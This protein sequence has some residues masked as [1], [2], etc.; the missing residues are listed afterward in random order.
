MAIKKDE[1]NVIAKRLLNQRNR[2]EKI[3]ALL[4]ADMAC[5]KKLISDRNVGQV[6]LLSIQE[7][8][9]NKDIVEFLSEELDADLFNS[10]KTDYWPTDEEF[11]KALKCN[12]KILHAKYHLKIEDQSEDVKDILDIINTKDSVEKMRWAKNMNIDFDN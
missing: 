10:L 7:N 8:S 5:I 3:G 1:A 9:K 6:Q 4:K 2:K 12:S 11:E